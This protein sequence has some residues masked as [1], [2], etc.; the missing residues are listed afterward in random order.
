MQKQINVQFL[1]KNVHLN[2]NLDNSTCT[3]SRKSAGSCSS[4]LSHLEE[5]SVSN[6]QLDVQSQINLT[7]T[8]VKVHTYLH[9]YQVNMIMMI[10]YPSLS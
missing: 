10:M 4:F 9:T 2:T 6:Y 8:A 3:S 5:A 7:F 1:E